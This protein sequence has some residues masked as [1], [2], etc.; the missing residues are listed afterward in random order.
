[1]E[2]KSLHCFVAS[3]PATKGWYVTAS[4]A[5][6]PRRRKSVIS[7]DL[8]NNFRLMF[9]FGFYRGYLH[10]QSEGLLTYWLHV[11]FASRKTRMRAVS[12][13]S[14][15]IA[16]KS[17]CLLYRSDTSPIHHNHMLLF[18][19]LPPHCSRVFSGLWPL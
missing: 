17:S 2:G 12:Q 18:P 7:W 8:V 1:M 11:N 15:R 5:E 4:A 6:Q 3:L 9:V 10:Y 16:E 13:N 19:S 14:C